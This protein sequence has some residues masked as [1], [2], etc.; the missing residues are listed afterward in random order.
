[1]AQIVLGMGTSHGPMLST[2]WKEW[3]SRVPFD[4]QTEHDF[5]GGKYSFD[6]LVEMRRAENF[7]A[8]ITPEK[9]ETRFKACRAAIDTLAAKFAEVKPD[10]AVIIGND[11]RELFMEDNFPA[12]AIY[13]GETIENRPRTPEQIANLP[14]GVAIAERGHAPPE[15]A[16]YPGAPELG[17]HMIDYMMDANF[18]IAASSRL[19]AGSGYCNGIPHAYG[20]IYRQI[21]RDRVIPNVPVVLNTFYPPNQPR[22]ARCYEFGRAL[23]SAVE[24]WE[25][26]A[27]VAVFGSG[28][29]SHF[30]IDEEIDRT[31]IEALKTADME[32]LIAI[33]ED[34]YQSGTSEVKNWIPLAAIMAECGLEMTLVDYVPCYRS[35]AGT[36]N[37]MGFAYWQ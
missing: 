22:A 11:Q 30:V 36:G 35:E 28:G 37:A 2:P 8:E 27:R 32:K 23:K 29:L 20:F 19:P 34:R 7:A 25:K 12:F 10:V 14:P 18:D 15:D 6:Q 5:R 4:R 9:W 24:S 31:V 1:M 33:P 26:D 16:V 17:R 13:W 3:A 21:M